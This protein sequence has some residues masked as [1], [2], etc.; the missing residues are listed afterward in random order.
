M[1]IAFRPAEIDLAIHEAAQPVTNR[2]DAAIEHRR[3]RDDDDVSR[4]LALVGLDEVIEVRRT[5]FFLAFEDDLHVDWQLAGLLQV[6]LDGLEMHEHLTLVVGRSARVNLA[7]A[8]GGLKGR[9]L[10]Q[11]DRIDRLHV[12][13]AVEKHRRCA[14]GAKPVAIDDGIARRLDQADVGQANAA[15]FV[16]GPLRTAPHIARVLQAGR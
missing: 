10:P 3:I 7:V 16:G 2:R 4:K 14:F 5:D 8:D 9:R 13:V 6:G 15:H 1:Q 11:L 12:V